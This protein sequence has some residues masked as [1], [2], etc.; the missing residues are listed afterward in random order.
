MPAYLLTNLN[1]LLNIVNGVRAIVYKIISN[2]E[3]NCKLFW[4]RICYWFC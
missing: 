3:S 4:F 2:I 1:I